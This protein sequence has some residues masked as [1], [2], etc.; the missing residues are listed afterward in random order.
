L[1]QISQTSAAMT[2]TWWR[3]LEPPPDLT[4]SQWADRERR[5]SAE[6]SAEPGRWDTARAEYQRGIMDAVSDPTIHTVVVMSSAQ[7]GKTEALLNLLGFYIDQDPSP[8]LLLQPTL[9]MAQAFSKDR[10]APMLRDTPALEG[11]VRDPKARDSGN[12]MLHK[13]FPGG[14]V[15]M[16]GANSPA[17]LASRP[18]RI[19]LADEVD[20]YP[21]SA[22]SEG[23]PVNL[24]RKRTTTF[25]NRKIVLTSTPTVKDKSRIEK[26]YAESDQ[27]QYHVPCPEC[28][29]E[30]P[31]VWSNV[32]WPEGNSGAAEYACEE[33]GSLWTD[34]ERWEAVSSGRWVA[35]REASGVAGFHLSEL[36][37]PWVHLAEVVSGFLDAKG[38]P[39]RMK[40]WSNTSLGETW[41]ET[42]ETV[43]QAGLRTLCE[44]YGPESIPADVRVL[45]A[46]VDVQAD[47]LEVE[48]V[49]WGAGEESAGIEYL[50][51]Y[52]DPAQPAL[53]DDLD[54]VLLTTF[55]LADGRAV[56]IAAVC[57]DSGGHFTEAVYRF[58]EQRMRRRIYAI[59]GQ[60]GP[61]PVWGARGQK[62][63][64]KA[65][66]FLVGVDTAK[67]TIYARFQITEPGPGYCHLPADPGTGYD[68]D[69][70]QG[71]TAEQKVTRFKQG[72][73]YS[74]WVLPGG[75]R[76]EPLDCRVYAYAA[77]KSMPR[78]VL[79]QPAA[80][81]AAPTRQAARSVP[82]VDWMARG[83]GAPAYVDRDDIDQRAQNGDAGTA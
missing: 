70:F 21:A 56:R 40:V 61:R 41:E 59:K 45:T 79:A 32:R 50:R 49:G 1:T 6:A 69:W 34:A 76:N 2:M 78:S 53:W 14:H 42:G 10:L 73:P 67:E 57:V 62:V 63:K 25:W 9:E 35:R 37:S 29:H 75:K 81:S 64:S 28:G 30:Q 48:I 52:G 15:T 54:K 23:D 12:T 68:D 71:V 74:L 47:R 7:V 83:A 27:R 77:L 80:A 58:C 13:T 11:K 20:R 38:D 18:I 3:M 51:L 33:C 17:S 31:L 66:L 16:A 39:E 24:A 60:S 82:G 8:V 72:R 19:V 5:L 65:P 46:G 44:N 4:V 26:A 43:D 36:Y 22:G 55:R